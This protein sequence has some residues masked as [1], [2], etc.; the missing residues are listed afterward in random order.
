MTVEELNTAS[1]VLLKATPAATLA[2]QV[3]MLSSLLE[4]ATQ[5]LNKTPG[6]GILAAEID[7]QHRIILGG[8]EGLE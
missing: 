1:E 4:L 2:N 3:V 8:P 5:A 7:K 6:C